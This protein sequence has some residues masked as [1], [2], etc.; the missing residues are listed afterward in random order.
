MLGEEADMLNEPGHEIDGVHLSAAADRAA[1]KKREEPGSRADVGDMLP[2]LQTDPRREA[3]AFA[4]DLAAFRLEPGNP[5]F[6]R[7]GQVGVVDA[8]FDAF[9][10]RGADLGGD[11][12]A[13]SDG[14]RSYDEDPGRRE[15]SCR[16]D[17]SRVLRWK[18]G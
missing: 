6:D 3:L 15:L 2:L 1:E 12:S 7:L 4:V 5:G 8:G 14:A 13:M 9:F 11:G 18:A 17:I 16:K 10:A